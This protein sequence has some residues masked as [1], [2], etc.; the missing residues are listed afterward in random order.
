[1]RW[2]P[3]AITTSSININ[4][5]C[6]IASAGVWVYLM[7][8]GAGVFALLYDTDLVRTYFRCF[9]IACSLSRESTPVLLI[10]SII[11]TNHDDRL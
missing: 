5:S 1:M 7:A 9:F 3:V 2:N 11:I 6:S 8:L 4:T 10:H